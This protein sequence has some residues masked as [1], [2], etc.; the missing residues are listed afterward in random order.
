MLSLLFVS[1]TTYRANLL[2]LRE[3]PVEKKA[4][5][6]YQDGQKRYTSEVVK[7]NNLTEIP[8]VRR[9]FQDA[10]KLDPSH[11]NAQ[12]ALENLSA[13][14]EKQY[15]IWLSAAQ[16]LNVQEKRSTDQ[17]Y[18]LVLAVKK[19]GD[20]KRK[21]EEVKVLQTGTQEV[22]KSVISVKSEKLAALQQEIK[23]EQER[24]KLLVLYRNALK[25]ANEISAIDP[26]NPGIAFQK[27]SLETK[28]GELQ[29]ELDAQKASTA[30]QKPATSPRKPANATAQ[31]PDYDANIA[32][33]IAS[34]DA[35]IKTQNPEA[36]ISLVRENK[37][38]MKKKENL[39]QL[40]QKESEVV[41]LVKT[42]YGEGIRLYNDEDYDAAKTKFTA[43]V[44]YSANYEQAQA[45]LDRTNTKI[46]ALT[47]R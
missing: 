46:R 18:E 2:L 1:C 38:R 23:A 9:R 5:L 32:V 26:L 4:D 30:A 45:Y 31:S 34:I 37:S 24:T 42:L 36:A 40:T 8:A 27:N 14:E 39:D 20:L 10:L 28:L 11:A 15:N 6:L 22:R 41:N 19:L 13:F 35:H 21:D 7:N 43:V 44:Q 33:V 12:K 47:G 25:T 29:S 3:T 17:D 16:K